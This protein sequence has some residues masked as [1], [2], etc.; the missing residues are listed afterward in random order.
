MTRLQIN[1]VSCTASFTQR[2]G[3]A[4]LRGPRD[5]VD[6][7]I[8][9]FRERRDAIVEGLRSVRGFRCASPRGAFYVWVDVS[10]T[11]LPGREVARRLMEE[12]G[13]ACV[14]GSAFGATG[15][16]YIRFSFAASLATIAEAVGKMRTL[17]GAA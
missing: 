2:A 7:M 13:V 5:E 1:S 17:F 8:A 10:G 6:S 15:E 9:A 11:G 16:T 12:A 14:A 3:L 4:A